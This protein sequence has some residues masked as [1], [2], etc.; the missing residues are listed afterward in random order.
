MSDAPQPESPS[1]LVGGIIAVF[2]A[3]WPKVERTIIAL[4]LAYLSWRAATLHQTVKTV[5][6]NQDQVI[7]K[8]DAVQQ[9]TVQNQVIAAKTLVN[10]TGAKQDQQTLEQAQNKLAEIKQESK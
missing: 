7:K 8:A 5:E 10:T 9:E 6:Q 4:F 2:N 3:V 1:G